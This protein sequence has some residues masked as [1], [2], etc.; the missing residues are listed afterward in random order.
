MTIETFEQLQLSEFIQK[1]IIDL[2]YAAPSAIQRE[3]IPH[4]LNKEDIVAMAPTGS[5][6]T[7]AFAIPALEN[8]DQ[9]DNTIQALVLCP[10]RELTIQAHK[11][12]EKLTKYN[13]SIKVVSVYGGQQ[14]DKQINALKRKPQVI[15]ATPGRLM[16]HLRQNNLSLKNLK[17]VV[18][19]EADEMLDMGFREDINTI[20]EQTNNSRQTVLF[21]ATMEKE[22]RKIAEKFQKTPR[23]VDV[24]DNLQSAPDIEQF[25]LEVT[26]KD[27][28]ELVSRLLDLHNL[29][30]AL[31]F[32]NT[33]SNVDM[34]VE[35]LRTKGFMAD[36]IHGDMNQTQREKVMQAFKKGTIKILVATDVAGRG[37]DVK[38]VEVVFNY[39]LPRDEEDYIHRIGRTGR[40]G[41]SGVAFSLVS[42]NQVSVLKKIERANGLKITQKER[43]TVDELEA[44]R[45]NTYSVEVKSIIEKSD[46]EKYKTFIE[47]IKTEGFSDL[48]IAA[49]LYKILSKKEQLKI[50]RH[51]VFE[52]TSF[53]YN[54]SEP[55]R[56][57]APRSRGRKDF[58]KSYGKD[59][60]KDFGRRSKPSESRG[61]RKSSKQ[62]FEMVGKLKKSNGKKRFSH[63]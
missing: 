32:C 27:K 39:D 58:G 25:Y 20:L 16:D 38:N 45:C 13:D 33:K 51:L 48:D 26:E 37:L 46:L 60:G 24:L 8:I 52:E 61:D 4:L 14:I 30:L 18:L 5:G 15:I 10:T 7:M 63:K 62:P 9:N 57:R 41:N 28:P 36:S 31:V 49:A 19:D 56:N 3:A 12:F 21:S 40:A 23:I 34:L 55:K 17:Y 54:D 44:S 6:K 50:N 59:N 2:G 43:P 22:I 29:N 1:A 42:K 35:K 47:Q 11:E 53:Y